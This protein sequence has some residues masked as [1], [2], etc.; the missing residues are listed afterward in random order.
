MD[1]KKG[2]WIIR[3]WSVLYG[4]EFDIGKFTGDFTYD[5]KGNPKDLKITNFYRFSPQFEY[6]EDV[7]PEGI[8]PVDVFDPRLEYQFRLMDSEDLEFFQPLMKKADIKKASNKFG[9]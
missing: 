8:I 5:P 9:L 6:V 3:K 4:D 2:D 1:F 7:K